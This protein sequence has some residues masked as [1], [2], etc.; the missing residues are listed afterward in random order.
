MHSKLTMNKLKQ[1]TPNHAKLI[2]NYN[3]LYTDKDDCILD[4]DNELCD[5]FDHH[6]RNNLVIKVILTLKNNNDINF[7]KWS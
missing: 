3:V 2:A 6:G 7:D 4:D 5:A 1:I